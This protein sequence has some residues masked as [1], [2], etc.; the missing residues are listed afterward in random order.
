VFFVIFTIGR[1]TF[2]HFFIYLFIIQLIIFQKSHFSKVLPSVEQQHLDVVMDFIATF[3]ALLVTPPA[4]FNHPIQI[5]MTDK[6]YPYQRR[7]GRKCLI[8]V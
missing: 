4:I 8:R 7:Y 2:S 6:M 1:L 3:C 5:R